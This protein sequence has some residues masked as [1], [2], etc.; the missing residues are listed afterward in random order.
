[1]A[2]VKIVKV[3]SEIDM[4]G[5]DSAT[6]TVTVEYDA[7]GLGRW[8]NC[9]PPRYPL[10][11]VSS[12]GEW[13]DAFTVEG[14]AAVD[15]VQGTVTITTTIRKNISFIMSPVV[16]LGIQAKLLGWE[17]DPDAMTFYDCERYPCLCLHTVAKASDTASVN[18]RVGEGEAAPPSG[19]VGSITAIGLVINGNRVYVGKG[20][21]YTVNT[22]TVRMEVLASLVGG[23][24]PL[25][26]TVQTD[27]G[28]VESQTQTGSSK[29]S[30]FVFDVPLN[31]HSTY[32][33]VTARGPGGASSWGFY[34]KSTAIP[35]SA[36][37]SPVP[38]KAKIV[39]D[40]SRYGVLINGKPVPPGEYAVSPGTT[41]EYRARAENVGG[42]GFIWLSAVINGQDVDTRSGTDYVE[43][44]GKVTVAETTT[45]KFVAGHSNI[46][47]DE[48]GC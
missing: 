2:Y 39:K 7:T 9:V 29:L 23:T 48:W 14:K 46:K 15:P 10:I 11:V 13:A 21:T 34:I 44:S 47:D 26:V 35:P 32:V 3:P 28:Y 25:T 12:Y 37:P 27:G 16:S 41:V 30:L 40:T 43:V 20:G 36:P 22:K 38:P 17:L 33:K 8:M 24:G 31:K 5:K 42:E 18:V 6:F 19:P 45:V 1:V 4:R